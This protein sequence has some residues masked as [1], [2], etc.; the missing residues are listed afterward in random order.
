M[1]HGST[2][3]ERCTRKVTGIIGSLA[4]EL[5]HGMGANVVELDRVTLDGSLYVRCL[6]K[7]PSNLL[8][9]CRGGHDHHAKGEEKSKG[10][11]HG[12]ERRR[13]DNAGCENEDPKSAMYRIGLSFLV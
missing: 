11:D 2:A 5:V 10:L 9:L 6:S 12:G 1:S 4:R 8:D 7:F 13:V 3:P